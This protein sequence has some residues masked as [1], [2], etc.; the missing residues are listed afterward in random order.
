[1]RIPRL[2]PILDADILSAGSSGDAATEA[3]CG[4]AQALVQAGCSVLQYRAKQL[5][6]KLALAQARELRRRLPQATLIM[7]DR[8]DLCLAAG[9]D[10]VH[11]GQQDLS[12]VSVRAVV[13]S[14]C[15][16]GLS[17]HNEAQMRQALAQP[18]DYVA[19]GPVF[20][21]G[22][23]ENP[24]PEVGLEG[25]R[26]ARKLLQE[27]G[28]NLPLVAIGG[29]TQD[30]AAEVVRAGADSLAVIGALVYQPGT[31]ASEFFR[32]MM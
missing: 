24:D 9:F 32:R 17:T 8:A 12:P 21:T 7:N 25:V 6:V 29:I 3:L 28:R 20:S 27:S 30:N 1:M 2:Y 31:S 5:A 16:V 26:R 19:I 22:S 23:K 10:G 4:H 18:V 15:I 14:G 13:G 11:A